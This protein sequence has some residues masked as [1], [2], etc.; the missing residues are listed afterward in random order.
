M[1]GSACARRSRWGASGRPRAAGPPRSGPRRGGC[2]DVSAVYHAKQALALVIAVVIATIPISIIGTITCGIG[3]ILYLPLLY[4]WIMGV[5][6]SAQGQYQP[7]PWFG[8]IAD[9]YL[10][11]IQADKRPTAPRG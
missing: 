11:S 9:K 4:P 5:V 10:Q 7:M 8:F 1:A 2:P 6:Y 3:F